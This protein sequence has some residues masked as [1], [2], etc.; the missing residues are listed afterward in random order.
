MNKNIL[1]KYRSLDSWEF[2]LDIL[3]NNRLYAANFK[4]LNDPMEGIFSY[5][6]EN[7]SSNFIEQIIN[8]K[9]HL[10]ICSLSKIHN[11][12]LMWSYYAAGHQGVVFGIELPNNGED[13]I[14]ISEIKYSSRKIFSKFLASDADIEAKKVLSKKLNPWKHE[15]EVRVFS[16]SSFVPVILK[17]VY[18]GCS[19]PKSK[20]ELLHKVISHLNHEIII[21]E[22]QHKDID[23]ALYQA[24]I[25]NL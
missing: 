21:K 12:T 15:K 17:E 20:K 8:Q 3:A 6:M 16:R 4:S 5:C 25:Q 19:M 22:M 18:L 13:G 14:E 11:S 10:N 1:Y 2:L 7:I 24:T 9:N 23:S